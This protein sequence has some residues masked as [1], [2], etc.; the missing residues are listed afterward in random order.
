MSLNTNALITV[1]E[2]LVF[3]GNYD[4]PT[5]PEKV[6]I[7]QAINW[8]SK[9]AEVYLDR[10]LV[11]GSS[12]TEIFD[13]LGEPHPELLHDR[14]TAENAPLITSPSPKLYIRNNNNATWTAI[15][16]TKYTYDATDG[17]VW[18]TDAGYFISGRKNY[19][20]V[21]DYGYANTASIPDDLKMAGA[22]MVHNF[23]NMAEHQNKT[24][25]TIGSQ[26]FSYNLNLPKM[27]TDILDSYKR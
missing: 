27:A 8:A 25:E 23:F 26:T 3:T 9:Q 2:Y 4:A 10:T 14:Y 11:S 6:R 12:A 13:G 7:E 5:I 19:R 15:A 18:F 1:D 24:N 20:L 16:Q 22:M 21:Y 17:E